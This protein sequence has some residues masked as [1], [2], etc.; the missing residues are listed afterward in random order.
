M[1]E[2]LKTLK[3][4]TYNTIAKDGM[5]L[6]VKEA[7]VKEAIL[8]KE[9]IKWIKVLSKGG[10]N[11]NPQIKFNNGKIDTSEVLEAVFSMETDIVVRWIKHFFNISDEDL[12]EVEE[13][14]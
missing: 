14:E 6:I 4:L 2:E 11:R 1:G 9:A 12:K 13:N 10:F 5:I 8:K 3:D 7:V